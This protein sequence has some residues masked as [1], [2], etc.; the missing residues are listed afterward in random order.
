MADPDR[1]VLDPD[2]LV[3]DPDRLV[4]DDA[5]ATGILDAEPVLVMLLDLD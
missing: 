3:L 5:T 4:L 2:K 1:L